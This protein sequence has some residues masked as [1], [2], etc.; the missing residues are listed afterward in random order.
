M[1]SGPEV[2]V[3][4]KA[5][6]GL[7]LLTLAARRALD[8]AGRRLSLKGWQSLDL[9]KRLVLVQQ[10]RAQ[11]VDVSTVLAA[12]ETAEPAAKPTEP[13]NE[14]RLQKP[15]SELATLLGAER[16]LDADDWQKL[17]QL[18]RFA[19]AH[20]VRRSDAARAHATY[21]EILAPAPVLTHLNASGEARMVDVAAKA[22][23]HRRAIACGSVRMK[24]ETA[25]LA[26]DHSGPKGD[27]LATARIAGIMA[28][29]Q[30]P[31]LIPLCHN[32]ALTHVTVDLAV[33]VEQGLVTVEATADAFDR[34][35]VEMEAMVAASVAALTVYDMLKAVERSMVVE[36]VY[37]LEKS[38]GR[39][40]LYRRAEATEPGTETP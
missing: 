17:D 34:T 18:E 9:A 31:A 39:T 36:Q 33:D 32:I 2:F 16:P 6:K 25:R 19:L 29:K 24:P 30:T 27:V 37:L 14:E 3:F 22:P 38:G 7:P 10:G 21:D 5:E 20:T 26:R 8:V 23:T 12:I 11:V 28:A 35:G 15:P 4:E 13:D 1:A 40:G